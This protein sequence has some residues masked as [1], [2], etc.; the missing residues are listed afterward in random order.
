MVH[1]NFVLT[2]HENI[3]FYILYNDTMLNKFF[4]GQRSIWPVRQEIF[5]TVLRFFLLG[6]DA[7]GTVDFPRRIWFLD[8]PRISK[9]R[10]VGRTHLEG[11]IYLGCPHS[12]RD[13]W[14][15]SSWRTNKSTGTTITIRKICLLCVA[16]LY[17][18]TV[19]IDWSIHD[20][21]KSVFI[22][23]RMG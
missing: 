23:C 9:Y 10:E 8:V 15:H 16:Y 19:I 12:W 4:F 22:T 18:L 6:H 3:E 11:F 17:V 1:V 14:R 21:P 5:K 20:N 7:E 13:T 2:I